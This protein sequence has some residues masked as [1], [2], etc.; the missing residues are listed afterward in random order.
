MAALPRKRYKPQIGQ[1][2]RPLIMGID[3]GLSGSIAVIDIDSKALIDLIDMPTYQTETK[4]R[5]QGYFSHLDMHKLSF[6]I[7]F[8]A[9]LTCLAVVEAPGAMPK[10]GLGS[11]F[12]FGF[13]CG[14]ITGV[15][16]GHYIPSIPV[17]PATWKTAMGLVADKSSSFIKAD[18]IYPQHKREWQLKKHHDRAESVLLAHY[19]LKHMS[20]LIEANRK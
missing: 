7:D 16:A 13:T 14:A 18:Q 6:E 5:V 8:Y 15:L 20:H 1:Q 11:T 2:A 9:R 19:G 12:T 17:P 4:A 10:Q 3:P